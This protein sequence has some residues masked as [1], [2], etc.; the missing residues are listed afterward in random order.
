MNYVTIQPPASLAEFVRFFW[1]LES[2][3]DSYIHRSMAEVCCEMV[4][5]YK[6]IFTELKKEGKSE[7]SFTSGV[8]APSDQIKRF[9][10]NR[11]FGIFGIYFFPYTIPVLTKTSGTEVVN[12]MIDLKTLL[13]TEGSILE[14][15]IMLAGSTAERVMIA[16]AFLEKKLGRNTNTTQPVFK[17]MRRLIDAK[18]NIRIAQL[19]GDHAMSERQFERK[20]KTFSGFNPKLFSR[21]IRF[22]NACSQYDNKRKSLTDIAHDCGYYD[23]SHFIHE[24]KQFSGHHPRSFFYG[25]AEGTAWRE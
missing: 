11:S 16:T 5:H 2:D 19:A 24:F 22:H 21:I 1:V 23:Q 7:L 8:Q 12:Q 9:S 17:A 10:V 25:N 14:E 20:F 3:L 4:F 13:G 15:R 6:G 18:G